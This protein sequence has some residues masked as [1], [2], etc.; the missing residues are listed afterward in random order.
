M[1]YGVAL[2]PLVAES[3]EIAEEIIQTMFERVETESYV[4]FYKDE[5]EDI[6]EVGSKWFPEEMYVCK[7]MYWKGKEEVEDFSRRGVFGLSGYERG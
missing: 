6:V 7:R 4:L 3:A 2:A 1:E 5:H